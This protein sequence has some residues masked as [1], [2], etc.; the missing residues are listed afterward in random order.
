MRS[1]SFLL[2]SILLVGGV[3]GLIYWMNEGERSTFHA[4]GKQSP[5]QNKRV[6]IYSKSTC[7]YCR[8][9]K[10]FL[11]QKGVDFEDID[12]ITFPH[13]REEMIARSG[14]Q[15]TVPQIFI[16]F[17]HI[18]GYSELLE[19]DAAGQLDQLLLSP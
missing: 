2:I 4:L 7:P 19:L 3:V 9:A 11:M 5:N 10:E 15:R 1:K 6:V 8:R 13:R 16:G 17:Q 18:G 14:G 12:L